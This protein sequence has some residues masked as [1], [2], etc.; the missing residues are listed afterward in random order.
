MSRSVSNKG[1]QQKE[2]TQFICESCGL[3]FMEEEYHIG[4]FSISRNMC[5]RCVVHEKEEK[6]EI[7]IPACFGISYDAGQFLCTDRCTLN[8]ACLIQFLDKNT[9]RWDLED[10]LMNPRREDSYKY[11]CS[12]VLKLV[13][14]AMHIFDLAPILETLTE[15]AYCIE[16]DPDCHKLTQKL[17]RRDEIHYLGDG[18]YVWFLYWNKEGD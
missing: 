13:G 12:R 10:Y 6:G 2:K 17:R 4:R 5:A 14:R 11:I 15:G 8:Q 7:Q 16:N 1:E 3:V 18:L 9:V